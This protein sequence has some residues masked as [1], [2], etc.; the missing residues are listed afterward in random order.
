M[1]AVPKVLD[2]SH[3]N[4]VFLTNCIY[5]IFIVNKDVGGLGMFVGD[6]NFLV[7]I[8]YSE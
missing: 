7:C 6:Q 1:K 3:D 5:Y 2:L 4:R 8:E